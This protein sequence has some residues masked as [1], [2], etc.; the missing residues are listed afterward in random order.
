MP[1]EHSYYHV[2]HVPSNAM[3]YVQRVQVPLRIASELSA[4]TPRSKETW[5]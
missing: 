1:I 3:T 2:P 5:N 4:A